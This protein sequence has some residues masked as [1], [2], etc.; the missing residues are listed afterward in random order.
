MSQ[1]LK[2]FISTCDI[3]QTHQTTQQKEPLQQHQVIKLPWAKLGMDLCQL[4]GCTLLG[5]CGYFSNYIEVERLTTTT[6][7]SVAR[8]LSSLFARLGVP[9]V[10]VSD[11]GPQFVSAELASFAKK[12]KFM[13]HHH[14]TLHSQTGKLK[15][16]SRL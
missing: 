2:T 9:D 4:H 6:S 14:H 5:V 12:W 10:L 16:Q 13:L 15:M 3:C 8:V 1:D 11:N 7:R